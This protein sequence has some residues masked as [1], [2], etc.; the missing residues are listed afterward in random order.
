MSAESL[1]ALLQ[2][3]DGLFPAGGFAHSFGLETLVQ[4]GGVQGRDDVERLVRAHLEVGAGPCD[5]VAVALAVRAAAGDD[6]AGCVALDE[7]VDAMRAVPGFRAGSAQM[8]RATLRAARAFG[9]DAFV[10]RL[11][12][13]VDDGIAPGHHPVVFG[14]VAGRAGAEA[15]AAALAYLHSTATLLVGAALRL[16][17]LGQVAGQR[18]LAA[19]RPLV[20]RLAREAAGAAG[21][22]AMWSF[23]PALEIAGMRHAGLEARLFRS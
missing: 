15:E 7:R 13:A 1:L 9:D 18:I 5:A 16:L 3:A 20:A 4:A 2:L 10:G 21:P 12:A 23:A 11:A 22:D 14:V 8:G 6:L 17:P 19:V